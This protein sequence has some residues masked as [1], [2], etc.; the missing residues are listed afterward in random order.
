MNDCGLIIFDHTLFVTVII[1]ITTV[2]SPSQPPPLLKRVG[3]TKGEREKEGEG[4]R[5]RERERERERGERE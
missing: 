1:S 4:V 3:S 2:E 5:E